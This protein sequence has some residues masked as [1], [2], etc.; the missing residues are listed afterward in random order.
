[1]IWQGTTTACLFCQ[2]ADLYNPLT[3]PH[4]LVKTRQALDKVVDLCYSPQ[5][6]PD[7]MARIEFLFGLYK[8]IYGVVVSVESKLIT[9]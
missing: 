4:K 6:F 7:E 1:M 9:K 5:A 2:L 8:K 3:M